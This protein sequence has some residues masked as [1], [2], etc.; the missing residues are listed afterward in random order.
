MGIQGG[1]GT[2][3]GR[4]RAIPGTHRPRKE[5]PETAKR[6]PEAPARGLEWVVS[7]AGC[8]SL[9]VRLLDHP[10][11]PVGPPVAPPCPG[12]L[13]PRLL[14]NKARID[15]FYCKVSQNLRVSP[16]SSH[17]ASHSPYFQNGL[18][19]SPLDFLRFPVL[20]AFSHKELM[21]LF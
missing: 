13:E 10:A 1:Y 14:A 16:K 8:V 7:G 18:I 21:G 5:G 9:G 15:L 19:K 6:A 11:G 20:P 4:G 12:P 17:K 3:V 2:R